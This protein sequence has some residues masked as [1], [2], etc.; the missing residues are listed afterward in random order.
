MI[1]KYKKLSLY[2]SLICLYT[3]GVL[4]AQTDFREGYVINLKNDTLMGE[5][6]YRGDILMGE[7]CLFKSKKG[8][9]I[10]QFEP[11][12]ILGYR[13]KDDSA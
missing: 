3:I 9:A 7:I 13:F 11:Q 10:T 2:L 4:K 5:I 1:K 6:N 8:G 12:N